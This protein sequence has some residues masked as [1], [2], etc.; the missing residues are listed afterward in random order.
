MKSRI[1]LLVM[2]AGLLASS[3]VSFA[4]E[5]PPIVVVDDSKS[6]FNLPLSIEP[7]MVVKAIELGA[8]TVTELNV[9]GNDIPNETSAIVAALPQ[10]VVVEFSEFRDHSANK[11]PGLKNTTI[12]HNF[13]KR[14]EYSLN[15]YSL[16]FCRG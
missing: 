5:S 13:G 6:A 11:Y 8:V 14:S 4:N 7:V 2:S 12:S 16:A 15:G 10:P 1:I 9:V 3:S